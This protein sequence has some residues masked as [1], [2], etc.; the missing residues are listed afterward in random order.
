MAARSARIAGLLTATA[1]LAATVLVA[2]TS[3]PV[4]AATINNPPTRLYMA[5]TGTIV[6]PNVPVGTMPMTGTDP[7]SGDD[8]GIVVTAPVGPNNCVL[9]EPDWDVDDCSRVQLTVSHGNLTIGTSV[10]TVYEG[11]NVAFPLY[12]LSGGALITSITNPP[13]LAS[14]IIHI[15]GTQA[16]LSDA[17]ADLVYI[18]D[19]GYY[20]SGSNLEYLNIL[21]ADADN[22]SNND[23]HLVEIMVLDTNSFPIMTGPGTQNAD[24]EIEHVISNGFV[25]EDEDND[26]NVDGAQA[27]PPVGGDDPLDGANDEMLLVAVLECGTTPVANSGFELQGGTFQQDD[28]QLQDLLELFYDVNSD[29]LLS[30]AVDRIVDGINAIAPDVLSKDYTTSNPA[31]WTTA[32]AGIGTML[33]VRYALDEITFLHHTPGDTCTLVTVISDLGNNGLPFQYVGDPPEGFEVPFAG[34]AVASTTI[35]VSDLDTIDASFEEGTFVLEGE[36]AELTIVVTPPIHPAF[37][38]R[39]SAVDIGDATPGDDY[40]NFSDLTVSIGENETEV[41]VSTNAFNDLDIEGEEVFLFEITAPTLPPPG[42]FTRPPGFEIT[43]DNNSAPVVIVD[44]DD[45]LNTLD[46][47]I[48]STATISE[49]T[50]GPVIISISPAS[51]P[52]FALE[53]NTAD[54]TAAAPGDYTALTDFPIVVPANATTVEV[55]LSTIENLVDAPDKD[56]QIFLSSPSPAPLGYD[57]VLG[58]SSSTVTIEDDDDPTPITIS[59][60]ATLDIAEGATAPVNISI[61]PAT[62]PA[63]DV[64]VS[65]TN[66]TAVA[67]G[68]YTAI[69]DVTV[70]IPANATSVP[71]DLTTFQNANVDAGGLDFTLTVTSPVVPPSGFTVSPSSD[72]TL[73]T[74]TDDDSDPTAITLSVPAT[75]DI[76]EGATAPVNISISPATHPAFDVVVSTTNGTAIAPGDYTAINSVTVNIPAN[77][78]SV[79]IDLTTFQNGDVDPGGLTFTLTI[80]APVV[81]PIGFTVSP[82][83]DSTAVTITDDDVPPPDTTNPDVTINEGSGQADP[84]SST[85]VIFDVVFTETVTGFTDT[86]VTITGTAGATTATVTGAG[87][88]YTVTV[89]TIPNTGTVIATINSGVATD[90]AA[91]PNNASTSTDNSVQYNAPP[92]GSPLVVTVPSDVVVGNDPGQAGA[93]VTYPAA[94]S[95][96][97][98]APVTI[99]CSPASGTFFAIGTTTVTC[100]ATDSAPPDMDSVGS[101]RRLEAVDSD[102]FSVTVNDV[103]PPT[104]NDPADLSI[105]AVGS[106][107]PVVLYANPSSADNVPGQ[108][109]SCNP[110]S[111]STFPIGTTVVTCTATDVAGNTAST[112]FTI[113]VVRG[114]Q[115]P[116]TGS[117]SSWPTGLALGFIL[118]GMFLLTAAHVGGTRR[119]LLPVRSNGRR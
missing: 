56:F 85:P 17:L 45:G 32:F 54:G 112:T 29:P 6:P 66:G 14:P 38:V 48:E 114:R 75:F 90:A 49:G 1:A 69:S 43:S 5:P 25:V 76:A 102:S 107:P 103:E 115:L 27:D 62:H 74:I 40:A 72:S 71:I 10:E 60:P 99:V 118:G 70:N 89:T 58:N 77:A 7:I 41:V 15:N 86:D 68:D 44:E 82:S 97:G 31:D 64:V 105:T 119:R 11:G 22:A 104:I 106:T 26:E 96:G 109:V 24:P 21:L 78:T 8:R 13:D 92:S 87:T 73:V 50:T 81:P 65:T 108:V 34:F 9:G 80:S 91:N 30:A 84:T 51:H 88:T 67:P 23:S 113:V 100:T 94:T 46:V 95:S 101:G 57:I 20:Y 42:A 117:S 4:S 2:T 3:L 36:T 55:D 33:D 53:V 98:E 93:T 52:A 110:P 16:Q 37:D 18:P 59:V 35:N 79:P 63:F 12:R 111:G 83:S 39:V 47:S 116:A 61:S 19:P 28:G